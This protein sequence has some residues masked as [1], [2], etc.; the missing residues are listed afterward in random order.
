MRIYV[1]TKGRATV[2]N[3]TLAWLKPLWGMTTIVCPTNEV[4]TYASAWPGIRVEGVDGT[5]PAVQQYIVNEY[6]PVRKEKRIILMDDDLR[7]ATR[8]G[9]ADTKLRQSTADDMVD[10]VNCI[11]SLLSV[12]AHC[13][14]SPRQGNNGHL[15]HIGYNSAA[16][17]VLGYRADII[18]RLGF[19]FDR[20]P[21]K[22]DYDM[23]LQLLREGYRIP[24]LYQ[25]AHD[26]IGG[27]T[28]PGGCTETRTAQVHEEASRAL[29]CYHPDFVTTV[30]KEKAEWKNTGGKRMDVRVAWKKAYQSSPPPPVIPAII[31]RTK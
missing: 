24:I 13:S 3:G 30:I 31:K 25:W 5:L 11:D 4:S 17:S 20:C 19:R 23:T 12:N 8:V 7:F 15:A 10:M 16:R 2:R 21:S 9:L 26:Q 14:V 28:L 6:A 18:H 22:S 29:V 27:P 1:H